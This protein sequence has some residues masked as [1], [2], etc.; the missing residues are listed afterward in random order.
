MLMGISYKNSDV[1]ST[2]QSYWEF[3][4]IRTD[5]LNYLYMIV[6]FIVPCYNFIH[7][8]NILQHIYNC[9]SKYL[10]SIT[11]FYILRFFTWTYVWLV[12]LF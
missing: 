4:L 7:H 3:C 11:L 9:E 10:I 2:G 6:F 8:L 1:D 12:Y 5:L